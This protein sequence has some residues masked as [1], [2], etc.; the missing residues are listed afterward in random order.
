MKVFIACEFSGII[1]DAFAN[2][3]HD[4]WSCDLL[5]TERAGQHIQGDVRK[6]LN[7]GWDLLIAH[8]YC[9]YTAV[10]GARWFYKRKKEQQEAIKFFYVFIN[11]PIDKICVE[12]PISIMSTVSISF[13]FLI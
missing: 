3:G 6:E 11:A 8:P 4:A 12:H 10:S 9:T 1:R 5:P 13:K 7:K 2:R